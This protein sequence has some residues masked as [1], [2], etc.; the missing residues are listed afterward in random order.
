MSKKNLKVKSDSI[1]HNR[2]FSFLWLMPVFYVVV[3][4][5][6]LSFCYSGQSQFIKEIIKYSSVFVSCASII[7]YIF[8]FR[9]SK[10]SVIIFIL[11]A[12]GLFSS[13]VSPDADVATFL[14]LYLRLI[15]LYLYLET[16][17]RMNANKAISAISSILWLLVLVNWVTLILFPNGMYSSSLYDRNWFFGYDNLHI[18]WFLAAIMSAYID[19]KI[20]NS[21]IF[22]FL[23]LLAM[24]T[25][26]V[27]FCM[28]ANSLVA[29]TI[30]M[31]YLIFSKWVNK[32]KI[33]NYKNAFVIYMTINILFVILRVQ[34]IL[35]WF[36]VGVL[37]KSLTFT[38]RTIIWDRTI[39]LIT[40]KPL[41]GYG[42]E[43][44]SVMSKRLGNQYYTHAHNTILDIGYK[45]G[46]ISSILF[47]SLLFSLKDNIKKCSSVAIRYFI[48]VSVFC[49]M[50]MMIF[51]ARQ[52]KI[53]FYVIL[54]LASGAEYYVL[55]KRVK[56]SK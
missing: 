1:R 41:L 36:I 38:G 23:S 24:T 55:S 22:K 35:S 52:E 11:F 7:T 39:D 30:L 5:T 18:I 48:T 27:L 21:N 6:F 29:Y 13:I 4:V 19:R 33:V 28:S 9:F 50:I 8:N 47:M 2:L 56:R 25:Y 20:N 17:I 32:I 40:K 51:E 53:G 12:I 10:Q 14:L 15:G 42:Y 37:G 26:S 45:G 44:S 43:P 3:S 31:T 16:S 34:N 54:A 46:I 49:L